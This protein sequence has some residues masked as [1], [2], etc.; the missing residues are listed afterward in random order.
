MKGA[1]IDA[2]EKGGMRLKDGDYGIDSCGMWYGKP[3]GFKAGYANLSKHKVIE[4]E[5]G[6]ITV[7]PSIAVRNHIA[8]W[9]GY[10]KRGVWREC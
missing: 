3:P 5:D 10:L 6:T 8:R 9:H 2:D 1:R 7:S 4:H